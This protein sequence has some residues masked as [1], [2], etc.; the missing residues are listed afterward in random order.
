MT[1][2][3]YYLQELSTLRQMGREFSRK[4]PGLSPYL[5]KEGQDPDV[6]RLLE[7]F[8]FL[9]GRLRQQFDEELPEVA[10][11]LAQLLWPNYIRPVP[12]YSIIAYEPLR[13][14][15]GV[16]VVP[17]G[18]E[19][20]SDP[21]EHGV[22]CK[23][24][25]CYDTTV[26]PFALKECN[27]QVHG[28]KSRIELDLT[29][30]CK[31]YLGD[32]RM[33]SL[34][35][36]L[37]G[38]RLLSKELYLCLL[39]YVERLEVELLDFE[40][41]VLTTVPLETGAIQPVGFGDDE[42]MVPYPDNVFGGYIVL[43]EYF[44]YEQKFLFLDVTQL[45]RIGSVDEAVLKESRDFRLRIYLDKRLKSAQGLSRENFA[46]YCTPVVNL[47][48]ADAVPIRKNAMEEE[49]LLTA[50]EFD[51]EQSEVFLVESARGWVPSKNSYQDFRAF[52]SFDY[53][54]E[55]EYYSVRVF[56]SE[57]GR[58]TR[59]YIRFAASES[60]FE[61]ME[62]ANATVSVKMLCTNANE[63]ASL[64]LGAIHIPDPQSNLAHLPFESVT[65]P[66]ESYPPPIGGDFLWRIVSNLSLNHLSLD[67]V[68]TLRTIMKTYD[69]LGAHDI[70]ERKK[71]ALMLEGITSVEH[72]PAE[73][74]HK[75]F[76]IRGIRVRLTL[77]VSKFA[78]LGEA[79]LLCCVLNEFFSLYSTVNAFHQLEVDVTNHDTFLWPPRMGAQKVM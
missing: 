51:R 15:P 28:S 47:F 64:P 56:L 34:R 14:A 69:F 2:N 39:E 23:F 59:S 52:E 50:S 62:H 72:T 45:E 16:Q 55:E 18:T 27:Y 25:T 76:P 78:G 70:K 12:S 40:G 8:A 58:R 49:Y 20:V 43:Q 37:N 7:G 17:R 6:E 5:A 77:D 38:S 53:G 29:M 44:A 21:S 3:D 60:V 9:T 54:D 24:R 46:L 67:D 30:S 13:E 75:G 66:S 65:V 74:I 42:Q 57:D 71:N 61:N 41:E 22:A 79:Y 68:R 26:Q 31:G 33:K 73:M 63:P 32:C 1:I 19:V 35:F 36:Y 11:N 48:E 10:H 4:N